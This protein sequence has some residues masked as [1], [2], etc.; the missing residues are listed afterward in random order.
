MALHS[1][2][3]RGTFEKSLMKIV[4]R[5]Q[6]IWSGHE[7]VTNR[8]TDSQLTDGLTDEGHSYN[9]LPLRGG[10]LMTEA[11]GQG[12]SDL[13]NVTQHFEL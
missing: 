10:G 2:S 7:S 6:D 4:P 12:Q 5:I 3:L 8:M 13:E 1:A 11:R 9:P